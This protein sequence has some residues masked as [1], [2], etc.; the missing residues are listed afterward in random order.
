MRYTDRVYT[1]L[2]FEADESRELIQRFLLE[3]PDP[4]N[5][6]VVGEK[7]EQGDR[8]RGRGGVGPLASHFSSSSPNPTFPASQATTTR[9]AGRAT[10]ACAS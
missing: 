4:N 1:V 8:R 6:N 2:R 7:E 5:E 9:S 3:R 10:R